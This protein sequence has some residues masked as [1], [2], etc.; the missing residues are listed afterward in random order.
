MHAVNQAIAMFP[1]LG[2][3]LSQVAGSLGGGE[4]QLLAIAR[5]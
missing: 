3:R 5:A 4:Q 1:R 2:E